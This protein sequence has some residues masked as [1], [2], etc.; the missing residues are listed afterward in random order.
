MISLPQDNRLTP[1]PALPPSYA[2]LAGACEEPGIK[3]VAAKMKVSAALA[4]KWCEPTGPDASGTANPLDRTLQL[5]LVTQSVEPARWLCA[6]LGGF[7]VESPR[8]AP[9][10]IEDMALCQGVGEMLTEF[11]ELL[12]AITTAGREVDATEAVTIR[13][14]VEDL[15]HDLERFAVACEL[16]HFG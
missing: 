7:Y 15:K 13:G 14:K 9:R 10:D 5:C 2:V 8:I 16:G 1:T 6:S 11:T 3:D 12:T 4:Y